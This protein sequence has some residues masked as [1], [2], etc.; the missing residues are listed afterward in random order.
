MVFLSDGTC[1]TRPRLVLVV[2][3]FKSFIFQLTS[4]YTFPFIFRL[5]LD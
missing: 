4:C 5:V 1:F 3:G 2:S